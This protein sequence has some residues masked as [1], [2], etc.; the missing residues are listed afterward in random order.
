MTTDRKENTMKKFFA[1]ILIL[2]MTASFAA[3]RGVEPATPTPVPETTA[4]P[5]TPTEVPTEVPTETPTEAPTEAP[6][7]APAVELDPAE[8]IQAIAHIPVGSGENEI[9]YVDE[10]DE[11]WGPEFF[12]AGE[13]R[14]VIADFGYE[15]LAID[16]ASGEAVRIPVDHNSCNGI[17]TPFVLKDGEIVTGE[18]VLD[19]ATGEI[20]RVVPPVSS[21]LDYQLGEEMISVFII[22]GEIRAVVYTVDYD[23]WTETMPEASEFVF[24]AEIGAWQ[25]LRKVF[26]RI[27]APKEQEDDFATP[28]DLIL[29]NGADLGRVIYIAHDAEGF[30]YTY[31][32][33]SLAD[34][35]PVTFRKFSPNGDLISY[36]TRSFKEGD[37]FFNDNAFFFGSDG[38]IYI[39]A[40]NKTEVTIYKLSMDE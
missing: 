22:D 23:Y 29:E 6:T 11:V 9:H 19:T 25:P 17:L 26:H 16:T 35:S 12:F 40:D 7:P 21:L 10:V 36:V 1:I 37:Y 24:N 13:D 34:G 33:G 20:T 27:P 2:V 28:G 31:E 18:Y 8:A 4:A 32:T 15:P 39:M 3:C 30:I 14:I 38:C 5:E